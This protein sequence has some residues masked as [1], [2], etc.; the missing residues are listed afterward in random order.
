MHHG[1]QKVDTGPSEGEKAETKEGV[2]S[3]KG[4]S[5]EARKSHA[6]FVSQIQ[7]VKQDT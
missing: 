2:E 5:G 1:G 4:H 3:E 6:V 7:L